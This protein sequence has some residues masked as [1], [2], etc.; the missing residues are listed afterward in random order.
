MIKAI[1]IFSIYKK[2]NQYNNA[3]ILRNHV[4]FNNKY[5]KYNLHE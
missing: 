5:P 1:K 4:A 3:I 2:Y